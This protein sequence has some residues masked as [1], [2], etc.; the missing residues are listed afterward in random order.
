MAKLFSSNCKWTY[1]IVFCTVEGS[2]PS[3]TVLIILTTSSK[4]GKDM[5]LSLE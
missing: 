2:P 1:P 3:D 5:V 4:F